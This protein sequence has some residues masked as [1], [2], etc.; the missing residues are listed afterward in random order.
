[1][2]T[3]SILQRLTGWL[4]GLRLL[5]TYDRSCRR[6]GLAAGLVVTLVLIPSA[7]AYADLGHCSPI[8]GMY[9]AQ[10]ANGKQH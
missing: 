1:M 5:V 10:V 9:A 3:Q 6:H 8:A 4:P 7:I 2:N